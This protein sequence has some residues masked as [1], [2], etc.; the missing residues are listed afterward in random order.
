MSKLNGYYLSLPVHFSNDERDQFLNKLNQFAGLKCVGSL[1]QISNQP[2]YA[3]NKEFAQI[4]KQ[5]VSEG[6]WIDQAASSKDYIPIVV[7]RLPAELKMGSVFRIDKITYKI[8]GVL[9]EPVFWSFSMF[10][11][12]TNT[13]DLMSDNQSSFFGLTIIEALSSYSQ[14]NGALPVLQYKN[15]VAIFQNAQDM[16][17]AGTYISNYAN[18]HSLSEISNN[19]NY[20]IKEFI[21]LYMPFY[22]IIFL[23]SLIGIIGIVSL[24]AIQNIRL[25]AILMLTGAKKRDVF[26]VII[27]CFTFSVVVAIGLFFSMILVYAKVFLPITMGIPSVLAL[28]GISLLVLLG[29]FIPCIVLKD[30]PPFAIYMKEGIA[31]D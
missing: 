20:V 1:S 30:N 29:S 4:Y 24:S 31:D 17:A 28:L 19:G 5:D 7:N 15:M 8:I 13:E 9:K 22:I 3:Y 27:L 25:F 21:H 23:L 10:G 12:Q 11:G 18:M 6:V 14:V 2:I 16:N 26:C